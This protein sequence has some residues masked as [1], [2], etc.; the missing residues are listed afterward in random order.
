MAGNAA[1]P[2]RGEIRL[3]D[4]GLVGNCQ[5][6]AHVARDGAVVWCCLPRFDSEPVFGELLDPD[7]GRFAVQPASGGH[8]NLSYLPNTNVLE[9][10]FVDESGAFRVLDLAPRLLAEEPVQDRQHRE[11]LEERPQEAPRSVP[12]SRSLKALSVG[13]RVTNQ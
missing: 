7:G 8:G 10:R 6:A 4:L 3:E 1:T 9:T 5:F 2:R 13:S 12:W 11:R